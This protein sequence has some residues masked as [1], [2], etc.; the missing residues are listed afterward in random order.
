M[1]LGARA[2]TARRTALLVAAQLSRRGQR[3]RRRASARRRLR[4]WRR[5]R[6]PRCRARGPAK[7]RRSPNSGCNSTRRLGAAGA[8]AGEL[9]SLAPLTSRSL[10][11]RALDARR[12]RSRSATLGGARPAP[13][14]RRTARR[15]WRRRVRAGDRSPRGADRPRRCRR[16]AVGAPYRRRATAAADLTSLGVGRPP[17]L[18]ARRAGAVAR[19]AR[20]VA[21]SIA[22]RRPGGAARPTRRRR[23]LELRAQAARVR[24][25]EPRQ[26]RRLLFRA[27]HSANA[28]TSMRRRNSTSATPRA[29]SPARANAPQP[30]RQFAPCCPRRARLHRLLARQPLLP[31]AEPGVACASACGGDSHVDQT[32]GGVRARHPR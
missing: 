16:P 20:G 15:R 3:R 17:A 28:T 5:R 23:A 9:A 25:C 19:K 13:V 11:P 7:A 4:W 31:L 8:G 14:A 12:R 10:A 29:H 24:R 18:G 27:F 32:E 21:A 26:P 1:L 2:T 22:S 30:S 6:S